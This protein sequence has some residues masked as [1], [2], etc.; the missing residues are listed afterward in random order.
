L[1][2]DAAFG[3]FLGAGAAGLVAFAKG[4]AF[5]LA[6]PPLALAG[7]GEGAFAFALSV[8]VPAAIL[9]FARPVVPV[10][11]A[12]RILHA[13]SNLWLQSARLQA[14]PVVYARRR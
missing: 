4:G 7:F 3:A 13:G 11:F 2:A 12:T 5:G 6:A 1:A 14:L 10:A 9:P 8:A